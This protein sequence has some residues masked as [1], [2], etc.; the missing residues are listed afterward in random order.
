MLGS[1]IFIWSLVLVA[2]IAVALKAQGGM[3][4]ALRVAKGNA[5]MM[6]PRMPLA[7]IGAGFLATL[8]PQESIG[9]LIGE[10][11]GWR[12]VLIA[13]AVGGL[14]PSGPIV[15]FPL[16]IALVKAGAGLPQ[17]VA[18]LTAWSVVALHRLIVWEIPLLGPGFA[19]LRLSSSWFLPPLAG[20]IAGAWLALLR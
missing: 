16:A 6:A 11:S 19:A 3:R 1:M 7:L 2:G 18:F 14:V 10:D 15:S 8:L 12:G 4:T 13:S 5:L 17:T 9:P 20:A